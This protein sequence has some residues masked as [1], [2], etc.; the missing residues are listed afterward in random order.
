MLL[1]L[2]LPPVEE[3]LP[4]PVLARPV[5]LLLEVVLPPLASPPVALPLLLTLRLVLPKAT[6]VPPLPPVPLPEVLLLPEADITW[7]PPL[8]ALLPFEPVPVPLLADW[9]VLLVALLPP[10]I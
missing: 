10:A 9:L 6:F 1:W 3:A 4:L 5:P 7:L 8:A 2:A